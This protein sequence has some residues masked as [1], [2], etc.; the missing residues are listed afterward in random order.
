MRTHLALFR[1]SRQVF[2]AENYL[3]GFARR[4]LCLISASTLAISSLYSQSYLIPVN[5]P[6]NIYPITFTDLAQKTLVLNFTKPVTSGSNL[7]QLGW[8]VTGTSASIS[9]INSSGTSVSIILSSAIS[10]AE[11]TSVFVSYNAAVGNFQMA[12]LTEPDFVNVIAVNNYIAV[13][14]DFANGLYGEIPPNDLCSPVENVEVEY[15]TT[16]TQRYRNSIKLY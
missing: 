9:Q 13:A 1:N 5:A 8:S 12:D 14:S 10:Y 15:N 16:I 4:I 2:N 7:G 6:S 11:R 3:S